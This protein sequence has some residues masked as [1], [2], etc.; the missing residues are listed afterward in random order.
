[1][2]LLLPGSAMAPYS[3]DLRKQV[4][5]AWDGQNMASAPRDE[6]QLRHQPRHDVIA[7]E[8]GLTLFE[9]EWLL[10]ARRSEGREWA[11]GSTR[12]RGHPSSTNQV[13]RNV[14][15]PARKMPRSAPLPYSDRMATIGCTDAARRAGATLA[16]TAMSTAIAGPA[17]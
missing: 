16:T 17:T 6:L 4:A 15:G 2:V 1:M 12:C 5:Q 8:V 13:V 14:S 9:I 7:D 10:D 3:M 11:C